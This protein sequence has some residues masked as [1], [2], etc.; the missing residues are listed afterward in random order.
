MTVESDHDHHPELISKLQAIPSSERI[1]HRKF[2][3]RHID[4]LVEIL[5]GEQYI[6]QWT[7]PAGCPAAT[8]EI[9]AQ[10]RKSN[11]KFPCAYRALSVPTEEV[12]TGCR[13]DDPLVGSDDPLDAVAAVA[14]SSE[15][16]SIAE[17]YFEIEWR[18][19]VA[20]L[21]R[22]EGSWT[23]ISSLSTAELK[24]VLDDVSNR[25]GVSK[26]RVSRL[27]RL[28]K[29][30]QDHRWVDELSLSGIPAVQYTSIKDF[31]SGL[32]GI[33]ESE[34][35]WLV[36]TALDKPV[37]PADDQIDLLLCDLGI[38]TPRELEDQPVRREVLEE[39]LTDRQIPTFHRAL[40]GHAVKGGPTYCDDDCEIRKF[41]LSYRAEQQQHRSDGPVVVDLF[42]GAG[43]ISHGLTDAGYTVT[44]AVDNN[45]HASDT[46][47]L[48]HPEIPHNRVLCSDASDL[49]SREDLIEALQGRVDLVVGGPPCQAL[50]QAGY[51]ARL[52]N[53]EEY[54]ILEDPRT[55]LY[56]AYVNFVDR[57]QP[58][59]I[60]IENVEGMVN[61]VGDSEIKV[62]DQIIAGLNDIGYSCDSKLIDCSK[63]GIPQT[64]DRV[65][66]LGTS[67]ATATEAD[68]DTLFNELE[69][70]APEAEFILNHGLSLLPRLRR[71][72]GGN[73][74]AERKPGR[75]SRYVR[76]NNL[77][78]GTRLTFNHQAREHP[79]DKD[80]EL[81]E[82]VMEPG[83]TGWSVKYEKG[84]DDLI[85]YN[86]GTKENPEFKDKYRMLFWDEPA[87]TV[88]AHLAKDANNFVIPDYYEYVQPDSDKKDPE[89]ARGI[90]PREAARLQSFPDDYIFL[91]P[92]TSQ[93]RQI[94]NAVP[95]LV[96]KQ[97]G[98][99]IDSHVVSEVS[100]TMA[101][102]A[103]PSQYASTETD[104]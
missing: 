21:R 42:A 30:L 85:E 73:V 88:V 26:D 96:S 5:T 59:A 1:A 23:E 68:I 71:G 65:L 28:L 83:D 75:P 64:R 40:A 100:T 67:D 82:D 10:K 77:A 47:R 19:L 11:E 51:R 4:F 50:S 3:F 92:F 78:D 39:E 72:E 34:A 103:D 84:R 7:H 44:L 33:S 38:L 36:L 74:V 41:T 70:N 22:S 60:V 15:G 45:E 95:P 89:R 55:E 32:P 69:A 13:C 61:E 76:E 27:A 31:L 17:L 58:D 62:V 99:V 12:L 86:V 54:S 20:A 102:Q 43:G 57:V 81:F 79:M 6:R 53:D 97:I 18:R 63:Y 24:E 46:Y 66:I 52:A 101:N 93:F 25:R 9:L 91:G 94:G 14:L 2:V 87:P 49:T 29:Q 56:Q 98:E 8:P 80:Q 104:D 35:W 90:T 37:W 48:N 16:S